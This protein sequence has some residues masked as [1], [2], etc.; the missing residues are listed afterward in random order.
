MERDVHQGGDAD[1]YSSGS[2]T[3]KT[4]ATSLGNVKGDAGMVAANEVPSYCAD[5]DPCPGTTNVAEGRH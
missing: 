4:S 5:S 1:R 3:V 2:T